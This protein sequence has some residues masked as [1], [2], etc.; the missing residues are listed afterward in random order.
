[1]MPQGTAITIVATVS[2]KVV[3]VAAASASRC[4]QTTDQS[5]VTAPSHS[6]GPPEVS[7][8]AVDAVDAARHRE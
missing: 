1:M 6:S 3:A 8:T 7:E 2:R 5:S 4:C